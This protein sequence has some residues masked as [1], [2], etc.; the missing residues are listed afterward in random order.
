[1]TCS[2]CL[3]TANDTRHEFETRDLMHILPLP[4]LFAMISSQPALLTD[5]GDASY[6]FRL[7]CHNMDVF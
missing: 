4:E 1:M 3:A 5:V 6:G 2:R 7:D